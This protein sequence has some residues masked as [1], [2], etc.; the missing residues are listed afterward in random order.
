[1][2]L[3]DLI[4]KHYYGFPPWEEQHRKGKTPLAFSCREE[5]EARAYSK[6]LKKPLFAWLYKGKIDAFLVGQTQRE[7]SVWYS[8]SNQPERMILIPGLPFLSKG[9]LPP[10]RNHDLDN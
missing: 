10:K 5:K 7:A 9:K 4:M 6:R 1:M 3:T 8:G 2:G